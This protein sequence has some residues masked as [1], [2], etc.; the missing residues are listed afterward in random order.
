M[1]RTTPQTWN[2]TIYAGQTF[3]WTWTVTDDTGQALDLTGVNVRAQ[4][5]QTVTDGTAVMTFGTA[6]STVIL[7]GTAGTIRFLQS[8]TVTTALGAAVGN[9]QVTAVFDAEAVE[10]TGDVSRIF[11]GDWTIVPEVTR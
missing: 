8:D 10:V 4:L 5:R 1:I 11:S 9:T 7:G 3:D 6:N 2:A